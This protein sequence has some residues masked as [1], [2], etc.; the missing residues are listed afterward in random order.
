MSACNMAARWRKPAIYP[1]HG[2]QLLHALPDTQLMRRRQIKATDGAAVAC[3]SP[4]TACD[5]FAFTTTVM[6][7]TVRAARPEAVDGLSYNAR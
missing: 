4:Q 2:N 1:A 3:R 7:M 6:H 5:F